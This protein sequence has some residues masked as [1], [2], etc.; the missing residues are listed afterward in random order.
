ME[1]FAK[2]TTF[3]AF[4]PESSEVYLK[5][6]SSDLSSFRQPSHPPEGEQWHEDAEKFK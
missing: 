2:M 6:R 4:H 5:S 1:M 3:H